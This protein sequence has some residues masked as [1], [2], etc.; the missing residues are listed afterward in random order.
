MLAG[1]CFAAG[2]AAAYGFS[3]VSK[4]EKKMQL[5]EVPAANGVKVPEPSAAA[6]TQIFPSGAAAALTRYEKYWPRKIMMVFGAP[7][8]GKGTQGAKIVDTLDIPQLSTGDMLREAV[9]SGTE[10]GKQAKAVMASGGLVSDEIV[11]GIIADRIKEPD[12]SKGFILDGFPRTVAQTK[13]LDE[14]LAKTGEA[15]SLVMAFEVDPAVLEER[16]CGRWMDK[17]SG[18]SYHVKFCPPKSMKLGPD[19]KPLPATMTDDQTGALLFQRPDDT[20]E[21]LIKR[22]DGYNSQTL[23]IL[24]HYKPKGIV[25]TVDGGRHIDGVWVEEACRQ[26]RQGEIRQSEVLQL[27]AVRPFCIFFDRQL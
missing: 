2:A 15:V 19:G 18:R 9:A 26:V 12:C 27:V 22:L 4:E 20:A 24:D 8:A 13:A 11:I 14:M 7:G 21:A 6:V 23:P 1:S 5:L 25:K 10:V 3:T 17:G 16:I